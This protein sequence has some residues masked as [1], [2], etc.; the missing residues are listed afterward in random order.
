MRVIRVFAY[1]L[2]LLGVIALA[3]SSRPLFVGR[4]GW[5]MTLAFFFLAGFML[6]PFRAW[7]DL[8]TKAKTLRFPGGRPIPLR[9]RHRIA[10]LVG[11][12]L[13]VLVPCE[14]AFRVNRRART[15]RLE[16]FHPFLQNRSRPGDER[17]HIN[18]HGFRGEEIAK[19]KPDDVF[20]VFVLG[21]STVFCP[22]AA[23]EKS[24]VRLLE[25][26][27]REAY[28]A[29]RIEVMNAGVPWYTT[30]HS[31]IN[32]LFHVRAFEPDLVIF[33]HGINDLFRSFSP[34]MFAY[35]A[36]REDYSHYYGAVS[37]VVFRSFPADRRGGTWT[38]S[39]LIDRV[40]SGLAQRLNGAD[41]EE[42]AIDEFKSLGAFARNV[43]AFAE[44]MR[45]DK[46]HLVLCTQ[47]TLYRLDLDDEGRARAMLRARFCLE[48][49][50]FPD[51][52]SMVRAMRSYNAATREIGM[53]VGVPVLDL[54]ASVPKT[55]E[56]FA[57]DCH[58]TEAGNRRVAEA[59]FTFLRTSLL[60]D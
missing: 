38:G 21:G 2:Y 4:W 14:I 17:L 12:L 1:A 10:F 25:K 29:R 50:R 33:M 41:A 13:L 15:P 60:F 56:Y 42:V 28:P 58:Y 20:R 7:L 46:V 48:D 59:M 37:R 11:G 49:G 32:Y 24:H 8:V 31:L 57:D 36:Y 45:V 16:E 23:W 39:E 19:R 47:P 5:E 22:A 52:D 55:G 44:R 53:R 27:L 35:G 18:A 26:R 9:R 30:Q 43:T 51:L 40:G 34:A 54:D 3:P 6:W